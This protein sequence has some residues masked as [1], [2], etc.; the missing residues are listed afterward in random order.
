MEERSRVKPVL[1]KWIRNENL[2]QEIWINSQIV[3]PRQTCIQV[4]KENTASM[5]TLAH[6]IDIRIA[7]TTTN[8]GLIESLMKCYN[9]RLG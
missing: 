7:I 9:S 8:I 1:L 3:N 2:V 4:S 5:I 6:Y